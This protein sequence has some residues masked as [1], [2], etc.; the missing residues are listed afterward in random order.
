MGITGWW[1]AGTLWGGAG[2]GGHRV[3]AGTGTLPLGAE[4]LIDAMAR[5]RRGWAP[6]WWPSG[7]PSTRLSISPSYSGTWALAWLGVRRD[8][9]VGRNDAGP[10]RIIFVYP[11]AAGTRWH[12]ARGLTR[13]MLTSKTLTTPMPFLFWS[14][15]QSSVLGVSLLLLWGNMGCA[16]RMYRLIWC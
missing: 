1:F 5:D 6:G 7:H 8:H 13:E 9:L 12:T 15:V 16:Y 14:G 2:W 3:P 10:P 11:T 4:L